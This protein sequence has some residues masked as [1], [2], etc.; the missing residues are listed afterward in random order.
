MV[1]AATH[2]AQVVELAGIAA[3]VALI[4]AQSDATAGASAGGAGYSDLTV[5]IQIGRFLRWSM[6]NEVLAVGLIVFVAAA[7]IYGV[8]AFVMAVG[9]VG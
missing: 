3:D 1:D 5:A 9:E 6:V 2:Q 7:M 4:S 8:A